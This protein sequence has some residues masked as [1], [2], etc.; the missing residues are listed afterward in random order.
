MSLKFY[1]R[2]K[3]GEYSSLDIIIRHKGERFK[4][5]SGINVAIK[6]WNQDRQRAKEIPQYPDGRYVNQALDKIENIFK[7]ILNSYIADLIIPDKD[8]FKYKIKLKLDEINK[9]NINYGLFLDFVKTTTEEFKLSKGTETIKSYNQLIEKLNEYEDERH[10]KLLFNDINISFYNDFQKWFYDKK[11]SSNYFGKIIKCI[12]MFMNEANERELTTCQGHR[13]KNF[14]KTS[15]ESENIYLSVDELLKIYTLNLACFP[16]GKFKTYEAVKNKFLIGAFTGLRVSDFNRLED[17]NLSEGFIKIKTQKTLQTV[18]VPIHWIIKEIIE[19]GF[20]IGTKISDQKINIHIKEICREAGIKES[21][22]I[23]ESVAGKNIQKIYKKYELVSTHTARR[24]G[25]T[26]MYKAG[27]DS[28]SIMKITGH[29]TEKAF[30]KYIKITGEE[31]A[32]ML[33]KHSFFNKQ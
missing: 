31:N 8:E 4:F 29:K 33:S 21:V 20:D 22:L 32:E 11:Y 15:V 19:S 17:I 25:A 5:P 23:N 10:V 7:E 2:I 14:I 27:I 1:L 26:N 28:I 3:T 24:S 18:I 9:R 16:A 12:K 6:Y 30:L 13:N